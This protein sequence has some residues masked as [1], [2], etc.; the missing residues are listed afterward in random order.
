MP[1]LRYGP[2]FS[3]A[4]LANGAVV[5]C[6]TREGV[7]SEAAMLSLIANVTC[8]NR[9]P[10]AAVLTQDRWVFLEAGVTLKH[11]G[12]VDAVVELVWCADG[13]ATWND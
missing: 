8:N 12:S 9:T 4:L 10:T 2:H 13:V 6:T 7:V 1:Q 5:E 3:E 11:D